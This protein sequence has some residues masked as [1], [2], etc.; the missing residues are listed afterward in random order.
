LNSTTIYVSL[1]SNGVGR[2]ISPF[3]Y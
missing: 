2:A 3:D 1:A